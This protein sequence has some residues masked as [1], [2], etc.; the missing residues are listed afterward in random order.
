M[1]KIIMIALAALIAFAA[2]A[3]AKQHHKGVHH[4]RHAGSCDGFIRCR[5]GTTAARRHGLAYD[6]NGWNLKMAREYLHFP[7]TSFQV[8][9]VGV[10]PDGHHVLTIEGGDSCS[11]ATVYDENGSYQRNVCGFTFVAVNGGGF[12]RPRDHGRGQG[13]ARRHMAAI[14]TTPDTYSQRAYLERGGLGS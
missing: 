8:G 10:R 9:A 7:R 11:K 2:P 14:L 3:E 1:T 5:C 6:Y 13:E 12:D 4:T